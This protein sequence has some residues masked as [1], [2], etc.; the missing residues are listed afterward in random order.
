[1]ALSTGD[2]TGQLEEAIKHHEKALEVYSTVPS[3]DDSDAALTQTNLG[4][5][6]YELG[7]RLRDDRAEEYIS[8]AVGAFR[9]AAQVFTRKASPRSWATISIYTAG[10]LAELGSREGARGDQ[11]ASEN[12]LQLAVE[13]CRNAAS[14]FKEKDDDW[15]QTRANLAYVLYQRARRMSGE[16][17][18]K[19]LREAIEE[20]RN[21]LTVYEEGG[22]SWAIANETLGGSLSELGNRTPGNDG[23]ASLQDAIMAYQA[24]V[25]LRDRLE[26]NEDWAKAHGNLGKALAELGSRKEDNERANLL[27]DAI[28]NFNL[29]LDF[30]DHEPHPDRYDEVRTDLR[31]RID[32]AR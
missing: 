8:K 9:A 27:H 6:Y 14:V 10:A 15:A 2:V 1:L 26:H 21:A 22:L 4:T 12:H 20:S 25:R 32:A 5:A 18:N 31:T 24:A 16:A 17:G 28:T 19:L 13:T 29:A 11:T 23:E 3:K 7:V 30:Y